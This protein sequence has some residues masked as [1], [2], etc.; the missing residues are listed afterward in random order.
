MIHQ[1][2][3]HA[4]CDKCISNLSWVAD[5]PFNSHLDEFS[6]DSVTSLVFYDYY[7][8]KIVHDL[9]FHG[10]GYYSGPMGRLM[11]ELYL[12]AGLPKDAIFIPVPMH[13]KKKRIRGYNQAEL[14]A[15]YA[16]KFSASMLMKD[17][18]IKMRATDSM[19]MARASGR[20]MALDDSIVL[21]TDRAL[22]LHGMDLVIVDDVIT[23]G[24]TAEKCAEALR[25]AGPRSINVLSFAVV[26]YKGNS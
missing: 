6:F 16:A 4:L 21:N 15:S 19:R 26:N 5:N 13:E 24:M 12:S 9:K 14:L 2:R 25:H 17:A 7:S 20:A 23:T 11:G 10:K 1:S 22:A 18:L 3:V 8:Q